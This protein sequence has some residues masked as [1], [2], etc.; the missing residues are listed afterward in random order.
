MSDK[1]PNT[2]A[3]RLLVCAVTTLG[4]LVVL[5]SSTPSAAPLA[6]VAISGSAVAPVSPGVSAPID[7]AFTNPHSF[8]VTLTGL[9]V[10]VGGITTA[11]AANGRTC[12]AA[13][14]GVLQ[15]DNL[16]ITLAAGGT[17]SLGGESI[18]QAHWPHIRMHD[19]PANQDGCKTASL[20][21]HY[22]ST[23]TAPG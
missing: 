9:H 13:D 1:V 8:P 5:V 14:F 6:S 23:W 21:L 19:L 2:L 3:P 15:A 10:A 12:N 20:T 7:L 16:Q 22:T 17:R 18:P 4:I 11:P